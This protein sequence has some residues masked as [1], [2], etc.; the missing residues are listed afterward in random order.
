MLETEKQ[1][2]KRLIKN[3]LF[4]YLRM[5]FVMCVGFYTSRVVL[6]KLGVVDFGVQN[7]VGGL[8]SM[9]VFFRSSLA[10][11]SQRFF[12][13]ALA[14][15]DLIAARHAF[16]QHQTVYMI[17]A[18]IVVFVAETIGV[19]FVV[20]KLVIPV[21][22][23]NAAIWVYQF[24]I[25][26]LVLTILSVVYDATM[27]SHE[28]MR[29]YSYV[30]I[31][32]GVAKLAIAFLISIAPF[33][34][35]IFYAMLTMFV[36]LSV[37]VFYGFYCKKKYAECRFSFVFDKQNIKQTTAF[38][39]WNFVGTAVWSINNQGIDVLLNMFFGP[40]V[41]AA[42]AISVQISNVVTNFSSNFFVS[43]QPQIT[44]SYASNDFEYLMKLFYGASRYSFFLL[45]FLSLPLLFHMYVVLGI[46]L[47]EV[48]EY[49]PIFAR[50]VL[51][52]ALINAFDNPIW[53][54]ALA[55]GN[56]KKYIS[57][58]SAV[59]LMNFPIAYL[60]LK[61]GLPPYSVLIASIVVR[62]VYIWTV[63]LIVR[64][65]VPISL[66][67]YI[68]SVILP[69]FIVVMLSGFICFVLNQ[70]I[71]SGNY[72]TFI[73][74]C[75]LDVAVNIVCVLFVGLRRNERTVLLD[76]VKKRLLKQ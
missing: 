4:L 50:L 37:R 53:S 23:L 26:S 41:N 11:A 7:V 68:R 16:C 51:G 74:S 38:I 59:Y 52:Y 76:N 61:K 73:L 17:L 34:K 42:R 32:E 21:E 31:Y 30:G 70:R 65:C 39:G 47:K 18:A 35:L 15:N 60:L 28:N 20:N 71:V 45:W 72:L 75:V 29:I 2:S 22:R 67:K 24:M 54:M 14:K 8:A 1:R 10:N 48:P 5:L 36:A 33:D 6:D 40:V 58:G 12:S 49:T 56:L 57:I 13:I 9:F 43:V 25:V 27:I 63:L 64:K 55:I 3:T 62:F 44:K 19:W 69:C 46:W 66:I